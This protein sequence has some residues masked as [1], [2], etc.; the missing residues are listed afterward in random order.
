MNEENKTSELKEWESPEIKGLE[1]QTEAIQA[2]N[3]T[4]SFEGLT[5]P[6]S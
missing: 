5:N 6:V 4:D 1:L 2:G 3:P